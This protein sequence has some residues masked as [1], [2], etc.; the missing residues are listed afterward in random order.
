MCLSDTVN[1]SVFV[2]V[3]RSLSP[4]LRVLC[5]EGPAQHAERGARRLAGATHAL[6]QHE[7]N[8]ATPH[9]IASC[10]IASDED[11][12]ATFGSDREGARRVLEDAQDRDRQT[13]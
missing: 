1:L 12:W 5:S 13:D 2:S 3:S 8:A 10:L 11:P 4:S 9:Q 6:A 7:C